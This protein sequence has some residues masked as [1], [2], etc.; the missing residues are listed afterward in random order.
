[1]SLKTFHIIFIILS[2][3]LSI[4]YGVWSLFFCFGEGEG[5]YCVMGFL[6]FVVTAALIIYGITFLRKVLILLFVLP[7][8]GTGEVLACA[9]CY[10]TKASSVT[11]ALNMAIITLLLIFLSVLSCVA[12]FFWK[13]GKRVKMLENG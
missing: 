2:I 3:L 5:I 9:V 11:S 7:L 12:I 8:S 6:S 1:M 4:G 13:V 10:G